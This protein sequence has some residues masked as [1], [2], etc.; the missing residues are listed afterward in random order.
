MPQF[1][2]SSCRR[3]DADVAEF[4]V[5]FRQGQLQVGEIF[6]CYMTHH[7]VG[8]RVRSIREADG[9]TILVCDG[10]LG[11]DGEFTGAVVDTAEPK[12]PEAFRYET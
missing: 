2:I 10:S 7:P 12:R 5:K 9:N 4:T 3:I 6:R 8:F 1:V 11:F